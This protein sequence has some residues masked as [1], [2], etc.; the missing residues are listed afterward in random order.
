MPFQIFSLALAASCAGFLIV[1]FLAIR[2]RR[3]LALR[4]VPGPFPAS[5]TNLW[6]LSKMRYGRWADDCVELDRK[7]GPVVRYGPN[8]VLFSQVD[9]VPQIY[10]STNVFPKVSPIS[11]LKRRLILF[12]ASRIG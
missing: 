7:Y 1:Y 12:F 3:Y 5:L 10:R 11:V 8:R 9:S 2:S 6:L 4:H